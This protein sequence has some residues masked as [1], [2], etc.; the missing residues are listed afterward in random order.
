[1][2]T[3]DLH[4]HSTV[5]DG[6]YTP[7]ELVNL[8][9]E[10]GLSSFALTD[11]DCTAGFEEARKEAEKL[12]NTGKTIKVIPGVEIS[13]GY[14]GR[15][16][17]IL[18]LFIDPDCPDLNKALQLTDERRDKRNNEMIKRFRNAGIDIT[19]E[20]LT[21]GCPDTIIT[22]GHFSRLLVSKGYAKD[23]KDSFDR[24]LNPSSPFFVAREYLEIHETICLIKEAGGVPVLAHPLLYKYN[25]NQVDELVKNFA[26]CGGLGIE[27]IYSSN[28]PDDEIY[29]R[30]LAQKYSL[31]ISGGTDFHGKCKP[32]L[33]VGIG[34]GNMR[35]PEN[36]ADELEKLSS[37]HTF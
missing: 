17:H 33:K 23:Y 21:F 5:S 22:R 36:L 31:A 6:S 20:E 37:N 34:S 7:A 10:A 18:G 9:C 28:S 27:A 29:V 12:T 2:K 16:I 19:H 30:S 4:V 15:D 24:Y 11:H 25:K 35:I 8:C 3:T 13:T 14:N 32:H 1:M 26:E